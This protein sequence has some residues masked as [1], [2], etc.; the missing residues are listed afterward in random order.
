MDATAHGTVPK[1][2]KIWIRQ[3]DGSRLSTD[4][5]TQFATELAT[6][7]YRPTIGRDGYILEF[8]L[9]SDDLDPDPSLRLR[10][11]NDNLM[12]R[13]WLRERPTERPVK[14]QRLIVV[15]LTAPDGDLV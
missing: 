11:E 6:R 13:M 7:G 12:L 10:F 2:A 15:E 5:A 3:P 14:R 9:G 4:L 1:D 8:R